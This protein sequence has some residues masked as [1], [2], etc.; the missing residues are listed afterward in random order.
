MHM[1]NLKHAYTTYLIA[2]LQQHVVNTT[3]TQHPQGLSQ[4]VWGHHQQ[5]DRCYKH[6]VVDQVVGCEDNNDSMSALDI[7]ISIP[8]VCVCV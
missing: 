6:H 1:Y 8:P 4:G 2:Q 3:H 5:Q 7:P